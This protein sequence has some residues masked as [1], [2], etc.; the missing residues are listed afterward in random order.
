MLLT[1]FDLEVPTPSLTS[2]AGFLAGCAAAALLVIGY[3]WLL[4]W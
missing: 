4:V 2:I 3:L 1:A